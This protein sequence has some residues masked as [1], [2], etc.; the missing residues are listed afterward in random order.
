MRR[1]SQA[2]SLPRVPSPPSR[3]GRQRSSTPWWIWFLLVAAGLALWARPLRAQEAAGGLRGRVLDADFRAPVA[4]AIIS[5]EGTGLRVPT[6]GEGLFSLGGL[7]AGTYAL[8][9]EREGYGVVRVADRTVRGGAF[10]EVEV[11]LLAEALELDEF[12]VAPAEEFE[13]AEIALDI[14]Q[15]LTSFANVMGS[16]FISKIGASDVGKALTKVAGINVIGDRY[17]VIRGL[18]DR[19]NAVLLNGAGVPSSDP[20]RRAPNIDLFPASIV[21][22]IQTSK[23]FTPDLPGEATGGSINIITKSIPDRSFAKAKLSLGY[24]TR[25]TGNSR[26]LTYQGGGTG[27]FGTLSSRRLPQFIR[28]APLPQIIAVGDGQKADQEFRDRVNNT[29]AR[30]MG[31]SEA[32]APPDTGIEATIGVRGT[33][34]DRPAGLLLALDHRKQYRLDLDGEEGRYNFVQDG[35]A[36]FVSRRVNV[37][38]GTE[39]LRGSLLLV[40]GIEPQAGDEIKLTLFTNLSA[41]D[42]AS[43]R[44]GPRDI[45]VGPTPPPADVDYY[46]ESLTYT[47]RR[48]QVLQLSGRHHWEG[49]VDD[50]QYL[51]NWF[52]AYNLSSQDEP[53][54]RFIEAE[55]TPE[56]L[57]RPIGNA[58]IPLFRRYWRELQDQRWNI[59]LDNEIVLFG[60]EEQKTRV[61]FGAGFDVI[62]REYRADNFAYNLGL[63]NSEFFPSALKPSPYPGA[64]WADVYNYGNPLN[65]SIDGNPVAGH[66]LFRSTAPEEYDAFFSAP[67]AFLMVRTDLSERLQAMFGFRFEQSNYSINATDISEVARENGDLAVALLPPE[68]RTVTNINDLL[69][70]GER[71]RNNPAVQA[72]SKVRL[73]ESHVLPAF[74]FKYDAGDHF[75]LR[76]SWSRT[77]AR[78]SFKE[79]A[80]VA[81]RDAESGTDFVGNSGLRISNIDNFDLRLEYY[82]PGGGTAAVNLFSKFIADPIELSNTGF[83]Q[84]INSKDATIYGFEFEFDRDLGFI[85]QSLRPFSV[86]TNFAYLRSQAQRETF[87]VFGTTRRLQGQPDSIFN[88]NVIYDNREYGLGAGL[89]LNV[90]GPYLDSVGQGVIPDIFVDPVTTL[91]AFLSLK[92]GKNGKV[93]LRAN[94][95]TQSPSRKVYD[96]A[97]RDLYELANSSIQY[98]ISCEWEW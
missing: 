83:R 71:A 23:T 88:F 51:L 11:D 38:R 47:E 77:I 33:F 3:E 94:N 12:I 72:A 52:A 19:Y 30:P 87:S 64:T 73:N 74:S 48:L 86:G 4:G 9:I 75:A 45:P 53:D 2:P 41:Q 57:Y 93:T 35:S 59:G 10:T 44:R 89:L 81:F 28:N 13:G 78:P 65:A 17:V 63:N 43:V 32:T 92:I 37:Q 67:S 18:A 66:Y 49:P 80:P 36:G 60:E 56:G 22:N 5:V 21:R 69:A 16:D 46:R 15:D 8:R 20:D 29:L 1:G 68:D 70:G 97:A 79:L 25:A 6:D 62:T 39:S 96:N 34:W 31:A 85:D 54:H 90:T 40:A 26:F 42:R 61:K 84:F 24:D 7:P 82:P 14:Q 98:S 95:L 27:A 55:I 91:N 58:V 50:E 76:G